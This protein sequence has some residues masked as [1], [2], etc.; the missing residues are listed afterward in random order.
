MINYLKRNWMA[1]KNLFDDDNNINEK[2]CSWI[3]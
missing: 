2:I 3:F 1:F